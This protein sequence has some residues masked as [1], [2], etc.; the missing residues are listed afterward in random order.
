MI[1]VGNSSRILQTALVAIALQLAASAC[2]ERPHTRS[3]EPR[4][5]TPL[6]PRMTSAADTA[7]A[8]KWMATVESELLRLVVARERAYFVQTTYI[9]D[10]TQIIASDAE[11]AVMAY[12]G[13]KVAEAHKMGLFKMKL[14]AALSR[15][16]QLLR[17]YLDLPAPPSTAARKELA[18]IAG[19]LTAIYGKGKHCKAVNGKELCRSLGKLSKVLATSR[20]YDDLLDAWLGW[21]TISPPMRE[22]FRRYVELSNAGARTL[23]FKNLGDLWKSRYDMSPAAFEREVERL[24]KQVKPLYR[25]LHC[26][27]RAKLSAKYGADKVPPRGVI[28]AHLLGNMWGQT[29][30]NIF[31]L[32][33]PSWMKSTVD[34]TA[35]LKKKQVTTNGMV[36]Y[37]EAFFTSLGMPTLPKTFWS[38]SLFVK[39]RDREVVCHASAWVI[40]FDRDVRLKQCIK[41]DGEDFGTLHHELGHIY[42]YLAYH[43]QA[44]LFRSGAHDGFHEGVGDTVALSVT[45]GYLKTIK[46]LPP[47]ASADVGLGFLM[48]MALEKVAFLPFGKLID[49]WRWDVF[50]GKITPKNYNASWWALRKRYQGIGAP[51]VRSERD[52]DP[53]A[54]F[55]VPANV[56]YTRYFLATILQFQFHRALCKAAGHTGPLHQC[57]IYGNKKAGQM[58]WKMLQMGQ[59]RPWGDALRAV[60]PGR[61][62]DATAIL[63][64]FKPLHQ[65][66]RKQNQGQTCG[67]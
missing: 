48:K 40:D 22:K 66:L 23:G 9:T 50:A 2:S 62:M 11:V 1:C 65:W 47:S 64:Y 7:S 32:V 8:R 30:E 38:R 27:V 42:Y 16:L 5:I 56:P 45:P 25:D 37:A 33:A 18:S 28:P 67:W 29:W 17:V 44:V 63:S 39:P 57:S 6:R 41:I 49:K 51:V 58:V 3:P 60:T 54:K 36:R 53:G 15:K 35:I 20:N 13:K 10:D 24:W 12:V 61:K 43:K 19:T 26:Y 21:R 52:F 34:L 59:S 55:H 14:P 46:L 31:E 4:R